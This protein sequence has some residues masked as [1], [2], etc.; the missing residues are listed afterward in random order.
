[1]RLLSTIW[2]GSSALARDAILNFAIYFTVLYFSYFWNRIAVSLVFPR[3]AK[4]DATMAVKLLKIG[5]FWLF[6]VSAVALAQTASLAC[7]A[8][9]VGDPVVVAA[10][11]ASGAMKADPKTNGASQSENMRGDN[12]NGAVA[13]D[14]NKHNKK[15]KMQRETDPAKNGRSQSEGVNGENKNG[16]PQ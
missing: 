12:K 9:S 8:R 2:A 15:G 7:G 5:T 4:G 10:N 11:D 13:T 14:M 16:Q 1:L 3:Q 6:A